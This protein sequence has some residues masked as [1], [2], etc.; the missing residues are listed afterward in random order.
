MGKKRNSSFLLNLTVKEK[1]ILKQEAEKLD[2]AISAY[3]RKKLFGE[4]G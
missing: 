2:I 4:K 3:I 1:A